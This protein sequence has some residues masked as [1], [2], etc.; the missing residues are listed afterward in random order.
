MNFY[1]NFFFFIKRRSH[2]FDKLDYSLVCEGAFPE[3]SVR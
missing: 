2:L 3:A 1:S